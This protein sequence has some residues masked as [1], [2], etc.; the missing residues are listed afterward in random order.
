ML[1]GQDVRPTDSYCP[2]SAR[3][4]IEEPR[5]TMGELGQFSRKCAHDRSGA[6]HAHITSRNVRL[7]SSILSL[8]NLIAAIQA[9]GLMA[10]SRICPLQCQLSRSLLKKV[11][12]AALISIYLTTSQF[13]QRCSHFAEVT[14]SVCLLN[15]DFENAKSCPS[16]PLPPA[17]PIFLLSFPKTWEGILFVNYISCRKFK[18]DEKILITYRA[19]FRPK[20]ISRREK[21]SNIGN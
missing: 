6:S 11:R 8:P 9:S 7:I 10:T 13:V 17:F 19:N 2:G 18:A 12:Q 5:A 20:D 4:R 3:T 14:A 1:L 15:T 21:L 16:R